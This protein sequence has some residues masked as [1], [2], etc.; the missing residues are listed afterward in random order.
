MRLRPHRR[1]LVVWSSS[2]GPA[3]AYD[4][5]AFRRTAS[6]GRIHRSMR[7]GAVLTVIGVMR[8]ARAVRPRWGNLLAGSVFTVIG[9]ILGSSPGGTVLLPGL[10]LLLSAPL[11]PAGSTADRSELEQELAA[12]SSSAHRRDLEAT[13]NRYPD[14]I[15]YELRDILAR[16]AGTARH[17]RIPGAGQR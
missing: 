8:L 15:T 9:I 1:D 4:G 10:L 12:Y 2:A 5:P 3:D 14:G 6:S 7:I 16:Q 11:I 13:L 17:S